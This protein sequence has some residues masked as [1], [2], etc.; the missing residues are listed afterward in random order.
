MRKLKN[1]ETFTRSFEAGPD[2]TVRV[3]ATIKPSEA[4]PDR[5]G[6]DCVMSFEGVSVEEIRE[7][8]A[9]QV[10]INDVQ[11]RF[12]T[13]HNS[14]G[15]RNMRAADFEEV[16]V[17]EYLDRERRKGGGPRDPLKTALSQIGKMDEGQRAALLAELQKAG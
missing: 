17:R 9:R 10:W 6:F 1:D 7:L 15:G 12:R 2:R 8:A 5:F 16:S 3:M 13:A 4:S 11:R 14:N